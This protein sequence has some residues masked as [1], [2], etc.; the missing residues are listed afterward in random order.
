MALR[1][2]RA[3][4]SARRVLVGWLVISLGG[5]IVVGLATL[6]FFE[7][8]WRPLNRPEDSYPRL[9]E[10]LFSPFVGGLL[11]TVVLA[12]IMS[13]AASQLLLCSSALV[14]DLY[15]LVTRS[16]APR[17]RHVGLARL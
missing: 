2:P 5:A 17:R 6:A 4:R 12:A 3:A 11:L 7:Q 10:L 8:S 14:E 13:S 15:R 16:A 1:T 9:A